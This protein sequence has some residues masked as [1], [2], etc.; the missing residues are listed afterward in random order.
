MS[1]WDW[2]EIASN[3]DRNKP[4]GWAQEA[5]E[6]FEEATQGQVSVN[7]GDNLGAQIFGGVQGH[8]F[9]DY[10]YLTVD[11]DGLIEGLLSKIPGVGAVLEGPLGALI[12]GLG[13]AVNWTYGRSTSATYVGPVCNIT[14]APTTAATGNTYV[15]PKG[16]KKVRIGPQLPIPDLGSLVRGTAGQVGAAQKSAAQTRIDKVSG[17]IVGILSV[18][19]VLAALAIDLLIYFKAKYPDNPHLPG[20]NDPGP[21]GTVQ[22]LKECS[23]TVTSRL[24]ALM[25]QVEQISQIARDAVQNYQSA[26][27]LTSSEKWAMAPGTVIAMKFEDAG[28]RLVQ[29]WDNAED[30]TKDLI[31]VLGIV[32]LFLIGAAA[33]VGG[34]V[35]AVAMT[36]KK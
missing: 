14:R 12:C 33:L 36:S 26:A 13:G 3:Q 35:G 17:V 18:L 6:K 30:S 34:V 25:V 8:T 19:M 15:W 9:G 21:K 22:L 2:V 7:L 20:N 27:Q 10:S 11:V 29:A 16:G 31:K 4:K 1:L 5:F 24:Q 23:W 28:R 32:A